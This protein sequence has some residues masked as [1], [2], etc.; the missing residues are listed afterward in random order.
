MASPNSRNSLIDYCLRRLGAPVLDVNVEPDQIEDKVDDALQLYQEYHSDATYR[1]YNKHTLT[2]DDVS[3]GYISIPTNVLTI[4]RV[5]PPASTFNGT[6]NF[7]DIKYQLMLNDIADMHNYIGD[8]AYYEQMQQ[9]LSLLD[10]KLNGQPLVTWSRHQDQLFLHGD[11]EDKD[12]QAGDFLVYEAYIVI[13]PNTSTSIYNDMFVK[14]YTTA[15]LKQQWGSNLMKFEGVSLPG[16]IQFNGRQYYEDATQELETLRERLRLEQEYPV[17][18][19][20][21]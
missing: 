11:F 6:R 4:T 10:I 2:A 14:D 12:F 7:F 5:F 13:D 15:L 9:Y 17:D 1:T 18:F 20:V 21:G 8:F 3:N 16:G 19:F